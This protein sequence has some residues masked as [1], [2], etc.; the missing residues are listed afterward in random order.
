MI[1]KVVKNRFGVVAKKSKQKGK[2]KAGFHMSEK[3]Q[4]VGDFTFCRLSQILPIR[5]IVV[6]SLFQILPILNLGRHVYV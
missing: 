5:R 1:F 6:G 3:S 4:T 2:V